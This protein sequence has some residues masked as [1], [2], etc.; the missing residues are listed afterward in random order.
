MNPNPEQTASLF[1]LLT[2]H[3]LDP[4]VWKAY[5]NPRVSYDEL[6][7][8]ADYDYAKNLLNRAS[9]V[10]F[11]RSSTCEDILTMIALT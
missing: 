2:Y 6:P 1:S 11:T 3:F 10:S 5:R 4:I 7:P 8:L 9:P